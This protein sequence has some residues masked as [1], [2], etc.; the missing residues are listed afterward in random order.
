M[1]SSC[2]G[3]RFWILVAL[4][5]ISGNG[6]TRGESS[7]STPTPIA[8][9]SADQLIA[10]AAQAEIAGDN[11]RSIALLQDIVRKYPENP[12]AHARLGE[13]KLDGKWVS[14]EEAQNRASADPKQAEYRE[15]RTAAGDSPEGQLALARWCR[16]NNLNDEARLHWAS[17]LSVDPTNTDALRA[18]EMRLRNGRLL[19]KSEADAIKETTGDARTKEQW[20]ARVSKWQ[21]ALA[22]KNKMSPEEA[23]AEI[24]AIKTPDAIPAIESATLRTNL[25]RQ[26]EEQRHK[27]SVAFMAALEKMPSQAATESLLRHALSS[28]YSEV[29]GAAIGE[30]R[31]RPIHDYAPLLLDSLTMPLESTY[32]VGTARDGSVHYRHN[33]YRSGPVAD[34]AMEITNNA[35]QHVLIQRADADDPAQ[36]IRRGRAI[37]RVASRVKGGF[38]AQAHS[39]QNE[40]QRE[41]MATNERNGRVTSVLAA[42]TGQDLGAN[43][44]D[45]WGWWQNYNEYYVP[46]N[47]PVYEQKLVNNQNNYIPDPQMMSCFAKGTPVWTKTG[48]RP[49]DSLEIGDLVLSQDVNTG[50]LKYQ[51]VVGRTIRPPCPIL[52]I[53]LDGEKI[54]TTKG[55]PFWVAGIGWRMAKELDDGARISA[56]KGSVGI[57]RIEADGQE[58]AY[59]L[60]IADYSTYFVGE[61]GLLVHDNSPRKPTRAV[62]PGYLARN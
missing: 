51:P 34:Y 22:G 54:R 53:T 60:V 8:R 3:Y 27:I 59:N 14:L 9:T 47:R 58:E 31:R 30:L 52:K 20:S 42:V 55:H 56:S 24:Q 33:L 2:V 10:A 41:N 29:R 23:I 26:E 38:N 35:Y 11:S 57:A 25:P 61:H 39:L 19:T 48:L 21:L 1:N 62:L 36:N 49:I 12:L 43:P 5:S 37:G 45:W 46:E 44:R 15:R 28:P 13:I 17:V 32:T 18:L 50:N 40:V 16:R 6:F 7:S 4:L